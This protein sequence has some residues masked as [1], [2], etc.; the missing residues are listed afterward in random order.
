VSGTAS[1]GTG[2]GLVWAQDECGVIGRDG[3]L[4]W[5]LPEDLAHFRALTRGATVLMGRATW[6]SLPERFRPLPGRRNVVL[7]RRPDYL[8]PGADVH[9][10]L[11]AALRDVEGPVWVI[12]GAQVYA[13]AQPLADRLVVTEV[14]VRVEGDAL[15][16]P[17]DDRWRRVGTDPADGF[18]RSAGG[19][20]YRFVE[21]RAR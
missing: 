4:P 17:L 18:H 3:A 16:P 12:G 14:A 21:Y 6:E 7:S 11:H 5:H 2:L 9:D 15:A 13:Q 1:A 20:E 19:L 8:A 10:S